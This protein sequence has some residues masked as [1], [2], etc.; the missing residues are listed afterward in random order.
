MKMF[1]N[2]T[3]SD[4]MKSDVLQRDE[5]DAAKGREFVSARM[6]TSTADKSVWENG[7]DEVEGRQHQPEEDN[8]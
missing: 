4:E 1:S 6:L 2:R 7:K 8:L 3:V 5:K